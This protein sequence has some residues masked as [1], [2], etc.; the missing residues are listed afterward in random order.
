MAPLVVPLQKRPSGPPTQTD[1]EQLAVALAAV[2]P[3]PYDSCRVKMRWRSDTGEA[4]LRL[5]VA[6][7]DGRLVCRWRRWAPYE[8]DG[9]AIR[10]LE[11]AADAVRAAAA[12]GSWAGWNEGTPPYLPFLFTPRSSR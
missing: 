12:S 4:L 7:P 11:L 1:V 2:T 6:A 10:A 3:D 8:T 9:S 5:R